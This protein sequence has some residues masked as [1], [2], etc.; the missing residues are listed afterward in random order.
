MISSAFLKRASLLLCLITA[1]AWAFE[2]QTATPESQ[3]MSASRLEALRENLA[4]HRTKALLV[5]RNDR[6]MC[7]WYAPGHG[8]NQKHG[9]ASLAKA[10]VGGVSLGVA[11]SDGLISLDD[12]AATFVPQWKG[13]PRKS[14]ITVRQLG[15][16]TSGIEDAEQDEIPHS[17]LTGWKGEFW[18]PETPPHDPFT[19]SRDAAPVVFE[20]GAEMRYSNPGI[21]MLTY[22]VTA[23]LRNAP[24]K[25][26]RSLLRERVMRPI[27]AAEAE[28]SMGYG[29]TVTVDGLPLV[30]SWGGGSYTARTAARVGRLML[31]AG[32]WDGKQ[33]LSKEAV[34]Q[35]TSDAGTPGNVGMGWWSNHDGVYDKV[36]K[37]AFWGSGAGHQIL[38]VVPSLN[39]IAVRNG[40]KLAS[41]ASPPQQYHEPVRQLLF[42]PLIAAIES[43]SKATS[44]VV[45]YLPSPVIKSIEWA[46]AT[47]IRRAAKGS[48]RFPMTW[49]DD[50]EQYTAWG[51][52]NGFS[53]TERK[54]SLGFARISGSPENFVGEDVR[55]ASGEDIGDGHRGYKASGMLS[56]GGTL[57]M[58]VS[59]ASKRGTESRLAWSGDHAKTWTWA[60]WK[61]PEFGYIS[62][63]NFERD[64]AGARDGF[65]YGV[66]HD[67]PAGYVPADRFILMRAPKEKLR[68]RDSYEFFAKRNAADE[69]EWT[70]DMAKR[71]STF[72]NSAACLRQQMTYCAPLRRYLWWQQQPNNKMPN[73]YGD[74][75]FEGGFAIYDAP[76]PWGPW[77]TAF[78]TSQWDVG[79]GETASF[80]T[81]WMSADGRTLWLMF[82]GDDYFSVRKA[83]LT[84]QR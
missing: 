60:E 65:V 34:R 53:K 2:W 38:L 23:S 22:C 80:P 30:G 7:E 12:R 5:I 59:N 47:T 8:T 68:E 71:G 13:D 57:Y 64:Y 24:V 6:I 48:D 74:T 44:T 58:W 40:E 3:G 76:E 49:A 67:H 20:P 72:T 37:D 81:K 42:E 10:L 79:P 15:S 75:R 1:R 61:F 73:D 43:G 31:R 54:L 32:D 11:I 45:P 82:S 63:V 27:G 29:K 4:A 41:T 56:V 9:T 21:A 78:S 33:L 77:T 69:P 62:L 39:L 17:E 36:P 70:R 16:H 14:K 25:N 51:D 55:S 35:I 83:T 66:A 84:I 46:S 28:W 19:V 52:G 50:G 26:I 18:K